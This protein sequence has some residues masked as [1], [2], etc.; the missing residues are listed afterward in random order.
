M[1]YQLREMQRSWLQ[2]MSLSAEAVSRLY[3]NPYNPLSFA[4]FAKTVSA[5]LE[6]MH[7]LGKDYAKPGFDL[8]ST[9]I[10]GHEVPVVER[11][12]L[13]KPFCQ[14]RK[15]ERVLPAALANR[16]QDPAILLFAPLSGHYATLLRDTVRA[17]LPDHDVY[18]TDWTDAR[19]VPT[20]AGR[21][22]FDEYVAYSIE[23]MRSLGP[24][25]NVVAVC[26]PT[27]PVLAAISIMSTIGDAKVPRTM[28]MMGGPIDPRQ[29]PTQVNKLAVEKDF[30][31]F[32][33]NLLATVPSTYPGAG[34]RVYPGFLQ[35]LAFVSMNPERH[36]E[37]H[38]EYFL[39]LVKGDQG[40]AE[41]HRQFYDEYNA[42]LD[43]DADFYLETVR[44]VFQEHSLPRGVMKVK[45]EGQEY[46]VAPEDITGPALLTIEGEFDDIA[47]RGQ[48]S[49]ALALCSGIPDARKRE[50]LA[51]GAGHYGIFSGHR[52]RETVYPQLREFIRAAK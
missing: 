2:P 51:E 11:V 6:L 27:V 34:R 44:M 13:T 36:A 33:N 38:W 14:L 41:S 17:M 26:Q 35:H 47:G 15:F 5:G 48:S 18:V 19:L 29:S 24:E 8:T 23:F 16:P 42:V 49:A 21:F 39:S 52:W 25:A 40:S 50:Y 20:S 22:G 46:R 1:L 10:E 28:T 3:A 45:F 32:E 30:S 43:M 31:W 12:V 37:S 4:P 9:T 7:R